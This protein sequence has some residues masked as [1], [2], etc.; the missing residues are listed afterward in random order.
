MTAIPQWNR[1]QPVY[2][3][4]TNQLAHDTIVGESGAFISRLSLNRFQTNASFQREKK[5]ASSVDQ[6]IERNPHAELSHAAQA[7]SERTPPRNGR[8]YRPLKFHRRASNSGGS[9]EAPYPTADETLLQEANIQAVRYALH[10]EHQKQRFVVD[11]TFRWPI[12]S[13]IMGG[14]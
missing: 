6:A 12:L 8:E 1:P 9:A 2:I 7:P 13:A 4:R 5:P 10:A 14:K 3:P 11:I